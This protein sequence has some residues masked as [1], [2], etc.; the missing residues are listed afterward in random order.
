MGRKIHKEIKNSADKSIKVNR[1]SWSRAR[2]VSHSGVFGQS[3]MTAPGVGLSSGGRFHHQGQ[4]V[5]YLAETDELAMFETLDNPDVPSL[6]WI[7]KYTQN[8]ELT[9]IL[10]LRHDWDN[11]GHDNEV[12]QALL[13]SRNI[14][15]KVI[16]RSN[17]WRPQY[18][19]TTFIA[20]CARQAGF[21]GIIYSS[22]RFHGSNLVLFNPNETAIDAFENPK[23]YIHENKK[24]SIENHDD[25]TRNF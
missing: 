25:L 14:F 22:S 6:V 11:F 9:G 8:S 24:N 12:I 13:A 5:L 19:L 23:V 1:T 2:L 10:D 7:Q 18:F 15:E 4:S 17:K 21:S 20:D 16:D 3:D